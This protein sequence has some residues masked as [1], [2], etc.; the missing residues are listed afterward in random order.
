MEWVVPVCVVLGLTAIIIACYALHLS[1]TSRI[2]V[3]AL[4]NSTHQVQ[5]VPVDEPDPLADRE[6][7]ALGKEMDK[8][9]RLGWDALTMSSNQPLA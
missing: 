6:E 8:A 9:E 3:L 4:K 5:F 1:I 7:D 2:E